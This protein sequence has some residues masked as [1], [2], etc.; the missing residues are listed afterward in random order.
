MPSASTPQHT[1]ISALRGST[2]TLYAEISPPAGATRFTGNITIASND[3]TLAPGSASFDVSSAT[4]GLIVLHAAVPLNATSE[5]LTAT[6]AGSVLYANGTRGAARLTVQQ[7]IVPIYPL[8]FTFV[9]PASGPDASWFQPAPLD[10]AVDNM[11]PWPTRSF[12]LA[13]WYDG[14]PMRNVT[15]AP[16]PGHHSAT[17][18]LGSLSASEDLHV[19]PQGGPND[20]VTAQLQI[21]TN[22]SQT[23]PSVLSSTGIPTE[24][25]PDVPATGFDD[26][27]GTLIAGPA[28]GEI[29]FNTGALPQIQAINASFGAPSLVTVRVTNFGRS[30]LSG[31]GVDASIMPLPPAVYGPGSVTAFSRV[32]TLAPLANATF[33]LRWTPQIAAPYDVSVRLDVDSIM[34]DTTYQTFVLPS[35]YEVNSTIP[36][37]GF[38]AN[39]GATVS[40][41]F[42]LASSKNET[43]VRP[44]IALSLPSV[45]DTDLPF[46]ALLLPNDIFSVTI[47]PSLLSLQAGVP[48]TV[49]VDLVAKA[50]GAYEVIPFVQDA[51][52]T[53]IPTPPASALGLAFPPTGVG[54]MSAFFASPTGFGGFVQLKILAFDYSVIAPLAPLGIAL[55]G[56]LATISIRKAVVR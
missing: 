51:N 13:V 14:A 16:I 22:L 34:P 6:L 40:L 9:Y 48:A 23:P 25:G 24:R 2:T 21:Y 54:Q 49:A 37:S 53:F 55:I 39:L 28:T 56:W 38:T 26:S 4:P 52:G 12:D 43:A 8:R 36:S 35:P 5:T 18:S 32:V 41:R 19:V 47:H 27:D 11:G 20:Q 42:T 29:V 17:V 31:L 15:V 1:P 10:V 45:Q 44:K 3:G 33:D 7:D 46:Q 30:T 50:A